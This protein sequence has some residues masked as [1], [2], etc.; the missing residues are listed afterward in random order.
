ME[1][2]NNKT[3][4][5]ISQTQATADIVKPTKKD[6]ENQIK[7]SD[8]LKETTDNIKHM[9][10]SKNY[11]AYDLRFMSSL[12]E[13]VLAKAPQILGRFCMVFLLLFSGY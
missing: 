13:A 5:G 9:V 1:D 11:D 3:S 2:L 10:Q 4:D 12:S 8:E 7:S 6:L